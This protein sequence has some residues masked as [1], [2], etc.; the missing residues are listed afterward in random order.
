MNYLIIEALERYDYFYGDKFMIEFPTGSG[1]QMRLRDVS[2]ELSRRVV[3]LF[4]P[5]KHGRRPCHGNDDRYAF[6]VYWNKLVLFY[7]YF[8]PESGR[9]LGAR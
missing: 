1:K 2:L 4:L 6:D 7:E 3:S 8:C 5:D 9:G